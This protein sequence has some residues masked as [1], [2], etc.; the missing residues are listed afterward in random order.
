MKR[1]RSTFIDMLGAP[2][3]DLRSKPKCAI[4][5]AP[6]TR[7]N[8]GMSRSKFEKGWTQLKFYCKDCC[9]EPEA[10]GLK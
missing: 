10:L 4:C 5:G 8:Y 2:K 6:I 9:L 3:A 1:K 7:R